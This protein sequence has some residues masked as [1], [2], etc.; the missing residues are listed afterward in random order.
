MDRDFSLLRN[1]AILRVY[2]GWDHLRVIATALR[3][4]RRTYIHPYTYAQF[5]HVQSVYEFPRVC[6]ELFI[7]CTSKFVFVAIAVL[8]SVVFIDCPSGRGW[9]WS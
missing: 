7:L 2:T 3:I 8:L 5:V 1:D 6:H 9:C 4:Q